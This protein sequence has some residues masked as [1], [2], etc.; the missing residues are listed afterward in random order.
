MVP[1]ASSL[2]AL[3]RESIVLIVLVVIVLGAIAIIRVYNAAIAPNL[4]KRLKIEEQRT[5]QEVLRTTQ[6]TSVERTSQLLSASLERF[7]RTETIS[8]ERDKVNA[9]VAT[10]LIRLSE[11]T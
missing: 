10:N 3:A 5:E 11:R 1:E 7:E 2:S 4:E 8:L 6:A 9:Q